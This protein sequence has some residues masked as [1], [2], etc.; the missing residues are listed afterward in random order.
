MTCSLPWSCSTTLATTATLSTVAYFPPF[1]NHLLQVSDGV[2]F[3]NGFL[4]RGVERAGDGYLVPFL[5]IRHRTFFAVAAKEA[6]PEVA[7][8]KTG[9]VGL[10]RPDKVG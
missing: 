5:Y 4:C 7:R 3:D 10:Y 9:R 6:R 1:F 8:F 2:G